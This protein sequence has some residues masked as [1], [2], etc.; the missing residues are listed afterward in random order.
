MSIWYITILSVSGVGQVTD[1]RI[2]KI[3]KNIDEMLN[4]FAYDYNSSKSCVEHS[5]YRYNTLMHNQNLTGL[6]T[7]TVSRITPYGISYS[8]ILRDS[9]LYDVD[10]NSVIDI[11]KF[12]NE[13]KSH[14]YKAQR[15]TDYDIK[16]KKNPRQQR[17]H[18]KHYGYRNSQSKHGGL[19]KSARIN[20]ILSQD[21]VENIY[22]VSIK[23]CRGNSGEFCFDRYRKNIE[24]NWKEKKVRKQWQYH[25]NVS[26]KYHYD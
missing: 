23:L 6:D 16:H 9:M 5:T 25:K 12:Q 11:R 15:L 4:W 3:F 2:Y 10:N 24:N 21:D 13:I 18:K 19:I 7:K 1:Y 26:C 17:T 8:Q 22:G 20:R 14:M